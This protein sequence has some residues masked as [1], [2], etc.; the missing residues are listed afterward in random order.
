[1]S[2]RTYNPSVLI[3]N[4]NE[5][6]CLEEVRVLEVEHFFAISSRSRA[7]SNV[8][9]FDRLTV[10]DARFYKCFTVT[11]FFFQDKLKDFLDKKENGELLI[12]KASNLLHSILKKVGHYM[13]LQY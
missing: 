10:F 13:I 3:G 7:E 12:Q 11:L 6:I 9:N 8:F 5:D 1:M 2:V 4:W